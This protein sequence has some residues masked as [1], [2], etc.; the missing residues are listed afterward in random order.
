MQEFCAGAVAVR[1]R[2]W[3]RRADEGYQVRC[4]SEREH[5]ELFAARFG[6]ELMTPETR[7]PWIERERSP[8][9]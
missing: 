2:H 6:G 8:R 5:A 3:F 9:N 4:F 1:A 7:P